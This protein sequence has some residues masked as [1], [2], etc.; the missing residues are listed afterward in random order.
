[1]SYQVI[2]LGGL[3]ED[4]SSNHFDIAYG[5]N[6]RPP[7]E[8]VAGL[9]PPD[10]NQ[11]Q[12]LP[13]RGNVVG[14][15]FPSGLRGPFFWSTDSGVTALGGGASGV[16]AYAL[17][18]NDSNSIVGWWEGGASGAHAVV[19]DSQLQLTGL[20]PLLSSI[21]SYAHDINKSGKIVGAAKFSA[22]GKYRG[23]RFDPQSSAVTQIEP[24][25]D[26]MHS[27][28]LAVNTSGQVV[29]HFGINQV[30]GFY[31]G[32]N[33]AF[34]WPGDNGQ[35]LELMPDEPN[36]VAYDINDSGVIVGSRIHGSLLAF[37]RWPDGTIFHPSDEEALAALGVN[38]NNEVV[39]EG[40]LQAWSHPTISED[41]FYA[42]IYNRRV[43]GADPVLQSG[44]YEDL[45]NLIPPNSG[46]QL[47]EA[48]DINNFGQIVGSGEFQGMRKPF[49]LDP[50]RTSPDQG[51]VKAAELV[52]RIF[53]GVASD[54]NGIIV[55][56]G[57]G[58]GPIGPWDPLRDA[59]N[60]RDRSAMTLSALRAA[61]DLTDDKSLQ[62]TLKGLLEIALRGK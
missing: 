25:S 2:D 38:N 12:S 47:I 40:R 5:I 1:M 46:W 27:Y 4:A 49:L 3:P 19:W 45:N 55:K 31:Q 24:P 9:W 32:A 50:V 14:V 18:I 35:M 60:P 17:A 22:D 56:P 42:W 33:K 51:F 53:G 7:D 41:Y 54:G 20:D 44:S 23:Y 37:I 28:A 34:L 30:N 62:K 61:M 43:Y 10:P 13:L 11:P 16:S 39:G 52:V 21:S 48:H 8:I 36:S 59:I 58:G 15:S 57:G 29:G 6:N 26:S